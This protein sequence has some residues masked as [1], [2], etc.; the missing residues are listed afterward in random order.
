MVAVRMGAED[1]SHG[2]V[3]DRFDQSLDM[4][5]QVGRP[6]VV[7]AEE[8]RQALDIYDTVLGQLGV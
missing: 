6:C 3:T 8:V 7:G 1:R 2:G 4:L 5:R